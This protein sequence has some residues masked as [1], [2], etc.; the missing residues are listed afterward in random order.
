MLY[1]KIINGDYKVPN[2][3][4]P[5]AKDLICNILQVD[6]EKRFTIEKIL[7]HPWCN[8]VKE[9]LDQGVL[10]EDGTIDIDSEIEIGRAHV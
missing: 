1:K 5:M 9:R 2:F 4:S 8:L 3:V 10:F 6:P 7:A